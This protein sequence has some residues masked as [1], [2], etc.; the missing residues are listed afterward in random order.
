MKW[1]SRVV[2]LLL[3]LVVGLFTA[4]ED[5]VEKKPLDNFP[6]GAPSNLVATDAGT[7]GTV[8]LTW[9]NVSGASSYTL[10]VGTLSPVETDPSV[11]TVPAVSTPYSATL[12]TDGIPYFFK[13]SASNAKG[14]S[15]LSNEATATPTLAAGIATPTGL[16]T[17]LVTTTSLTLSW[18]PVPGATSYSVYRG[19]PGTGT[20]AD[21]LAGNPGTNSFADSGLTAGTT[22][23]YTV[24]AFDGTN[25]SLDSAPL[26]V[27]TVPP[28]PTA[29]AANPTG[30]TTE[31]QITWT[32]APGAASHTVYY[33][34]GITGVTTADT[35][36]PGSLSG[37]IINVPLDNTDYVFAV[38]ADN[39]SGSS[40]LSGEAT[41]QANA[42]G[43]L[44]APAGLGVT[45]VTGTTLTLSWG[46]VVGATSYTIYRGAPGTGTSG[47]PMAGTSGTTSFADTLL[48]PGTTYQYTVTATDGVGTSL[49]SAPFSVTTLPAAPTL[50]NA[51]PN[52]QM[53]GVN[54]TQV[55]SA[56]SYRV[57]Y[58]VGA[59]VNTGTS[60]FITEPDPPTFPVNIPGLTNPFLYYVVVSA[61]NGS[62]E[63]PPSN[64]LTASPSITVGIDMIPPPPF[65]NTTVWQYFGFKPADT[66]T[67]L[68]VR[69]APPYGDLVSDPD[70]YVFNDPF[71]TTSMGNTQYLAGTAERFHFVPASTN[72]HTFYVEP[73]VSPSSYTVTVTTDAVTGAPGAPVDGS[74]TT[75]VT[76]APINEGE[77]IAIAPAMANLGIYYYNF[78]TSTAGLYTIKLTN[79]TDDMDWWLYTSDLDFGVVGPEI[80]A[81]KDNDLTNTPA[82]GSEA[83]SVN[84]AGAT[85]YY[86]EVDSYGPANT[87]NLSIIKH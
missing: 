37:V 66:V 72:R 21:P 29:L 44:A 18:N 15:G 30:N 76:S 84:L 24:T 65:N 49:D 5:V 39:A 42:T 14:E 10:Y 47:D 74:L 16:A 26:S 48:T 64:E 82:N 3:I 51:I 61:V 78:T 54:F 53:I 1:N 25:T 67:G 13:V 60:P 35:S 28:P 83:C 9:N 31:I 71:F 45:L 19:A 70:M 38:T 52:N 79:L 34:A 50:N 41:A 17:S 43:G 63:G 68:L 46:S 75:P 4:C 59:S 27:T 33:R 69:V 81:C 80:I 32:D 12:L 11:V 85:T 22:Y 36:F 62:G 56:T 2:A 77:W 7:G 23:Q 8:D 40:G 20:S 86:L 57:Y 73:F 6:P 55:P 58:E 87:G